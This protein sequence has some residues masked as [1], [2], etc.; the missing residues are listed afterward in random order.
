MLVRAPRLAAA[1]VFLVPLTLPAQSFEYAASSGQ[2]RVTTKTT[3]TR[4]A[5][6]QTQQFDAATSELLS[7]VVARSTKDT[8]TLSVTIDSATGTGPMGMPMPGFDRLP[9]KKV[10]A[11]LSP[12]GNVYTAQGP[13]DD[14]LPNGAQFTTELSRLLPRVK[15]ALSSGATWVDT[16]KTSLHNNGLDLDRQAISTYHVTGDTTVGGASGWKVTRQSAITMTGGG[17]TQGQ[18]VALESSGTGTGTFVVS[19]SGV[20]L[21]AMGDEDS[22]VKITLTAQAAEITGTN[23]THITV[24]KVK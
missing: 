23:K 1:I 16:V 12:S 18:L 11:K 13:T 14:S 17:T 7:M 21:G 4:E 22:N 10:V 19:K 3:G 20:F 24:D 15:S 8:M 9:G 6:G 5:M 2:Y